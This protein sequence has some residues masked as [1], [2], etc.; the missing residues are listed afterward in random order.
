ME[1]ASGLDDNDDSSSSSSSPP[2]DNKQRTPSPRQQPRSVHFSSSPDTTIEDKENCSRDKEAYVS[3]HDLFYT[4]E[5]IQQFR[6]DAMREQDTLNLRLVLRILAKSS[7][8]RLVASPGSRQCQVLES[9]QVLERLQQTKFFQEEQQKQEE[10]AASAPKDQS[11]D[12]SQEEDITPSEEP[13]T[14]GR[15]TLPPKR[16]S[17]RSIQSTSNSS[18]RSLRDS[19]RSLRGNSQR[20]LHP[21]RRSTISIASG[22]GSSREFSTSRDNISRELHVKEDE[23]QPSPFG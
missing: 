22:D 15:P 21:P 13:N 19:Q 17:R 2:S 16:E 8:R 6:L 20:S 10:A 5:E 1:N 4:A 11:A 12:T 23:T 3:A 7:T 18:S 9:S 14:Q